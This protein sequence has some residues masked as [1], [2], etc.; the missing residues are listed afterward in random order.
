MDAHRFDRFARALAGRLSRRTALTAGGGG[1]A[2]ALL[3]AGRSSG[4][5]QE[6]TPDASPVASPAAS[7]A[8]GAGP[9]FLFVQTFAEGTWTPKPDV[10]GVYDLT[11]TGHAAQTVYFS[12]RPD[13]I[14][15]TV[16]T[17]EFL[18]RAGFT[19]DDPPNAAVVVQAP[20]GGEDVLVVELFDPVYTQ[21]FGEDGGVSLTYAAR[22]L[23]GEPGERLSSLAARQGDGQL[24]ES[25]GSA[26]LFID[27]VAEAQ[28]V[29]REHVWGCFARSGGSLLTSPAGYV[30]VP[31]C[32]TW[33]P[34]GCDWTNCDRPTA[35]TGLCERKFPRGKNSPCGEQGCVACEGFP[36]RRDTRCN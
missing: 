1:L 16:P 13:R 6:A 24:P 31:Y 23:A 34:T 10:D 9:E 2:A 29:C 21:G 27:G 32:W 4:T 36:G 8:A 3:A 28:D 14:V 30:N 15:G 22:V 17:R 5:A 20:E 33:W 35:P 18:D 19:P 12:D 25:F 11:L 7:P 26:S